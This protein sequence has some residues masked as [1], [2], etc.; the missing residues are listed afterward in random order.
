MRNIALN[1]QN[2]GITGIIYVLV[3]LFRHVIQS[4]IHILEMQFVRRVENN[5]ENSQQSA[6]VLNI[7][8]LCQTLSWRTRNG[9]HFINI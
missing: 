2:L 9:P 3:S 4:L 1:E 6:F 5:K 7:T 8:K